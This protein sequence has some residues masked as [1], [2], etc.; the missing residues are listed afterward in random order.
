MICSKTQKEVETEIGMC[1]R[2]ALSLNPLISL[3]S[4]DISVFSL[5]NLERCKEEIRI[6]ESSH[7]TVIGYL[8]RKIKAIEEDINGA[9]GLMNK[10][11]EELKEKLYMIQADREVQLKELLN[12]RLRQ[13]LEDEMREKLEAETRAMIE[14]E[15]EQER[16]DVMASKIQTVFRFFIQVKYEKIKAIKSSK[17]ENKGNKKTKKK[18]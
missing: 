9:Q 11:L 3:F 12:L 16:K 1:I 14:K 6:Q 10:S 8:N 17:G 4:Y 18:Q 5:Y 13:K 2:N 7:T 15:K